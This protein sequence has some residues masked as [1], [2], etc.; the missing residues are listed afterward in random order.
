[1]D[2]DLENVIRSA[3]EAAARLTVSRLCGGTH[4][5]ATEEHQPATEEHA[6]VSAFQRSASKPAGQRSVSNFD[7]EDELRGPL[8]NVRFGSQPEVSDGHENVGFRG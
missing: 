8:V 1:M 4:Q 2:P 3:L 6:W 7:D 5:P